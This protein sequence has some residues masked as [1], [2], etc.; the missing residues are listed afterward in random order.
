M[1]SRRVWFSIGSNL[2]DRQA[3]LQHAVD[4]MVSSGDFEDIAVSRVWVTAP[5][6]GLS[7]P[8][9]LNA[10]VQAR[11]ALSAQG[12]L[13]FAQRCEAQR[14]RVR[15]QRW[16]PRTL[17]VDII[18]IE[19]EQHE[20]P[21]LTVPHPRARKRGFVLLPLSDLVDPETLLGQISAP[22]AAAVYVSDIRLQVA[23]PAAG[24]NRRQADDE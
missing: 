3:H 17:D 16:G 12:L 14:D 23:A 21:S 2:G 22:D 6:G 19:G 11:T 18:A 4:Q 5:V 13:Q 7:Q 24:S 9:F 15:D 8:D 10:V 1:S 20:S